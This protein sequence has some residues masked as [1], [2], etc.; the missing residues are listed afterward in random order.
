M[1]LATVAASFE[2]IEILLSILLASYFVQHSIGNI[3]HC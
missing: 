1:Q 3:H 2:T